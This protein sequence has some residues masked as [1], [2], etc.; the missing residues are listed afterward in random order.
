MSEIDRADLLNALERALRHRD[1][2]AATLIEVQRE[3]RAAIE[4]LDDHRCTA[5]AE[6]AYARTIRAEDERTGLAAQI[7]RVRALHVR[8][9]EWCNF[10]ESARCECADAYC[11]ECGDSYPCPTIQALDGGE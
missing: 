1:S 3:K 6:R 9:D 7:E 8:G 5:S 10:H 2:L 11:E 4:M